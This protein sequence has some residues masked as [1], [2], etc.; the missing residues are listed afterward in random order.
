[1]AL[2]EVQQFMLGKVGSRVKYSVANKTNIPKNTIALM[3]IRDIVTFGL[4]PGGC[5]FSSRNG[6]I[7]Y[8]LLLEFV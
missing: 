4:K 7:S 8:S 2:T 6:N 3:I 1:M 5:G